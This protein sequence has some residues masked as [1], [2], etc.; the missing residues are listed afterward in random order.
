MSIRSLYM[1]LIFLIK[2]RHLFVLKPQRDVLL[3]STMIYWPTYKRVC[4][5]LNTDLTT[6]GVNHESENHEHDLLFMSDAYVRG[7]D[8]DYP[9]DN[10]P[11]TMLMN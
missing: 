9:P 1:S 11:A 10:Q 8:K 4:S 6:T 5:R 3:I 2:P 7:K